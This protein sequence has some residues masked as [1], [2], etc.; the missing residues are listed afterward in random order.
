MKYIQ[1]TLPCSFP[2]ADSKY[3]INDAISRGKYTF[4]RNCS[5][6]D[7]N[8]WLFNYLS[9]FLFDFNLNNESILNM[10]NNGSK[11]SNNKT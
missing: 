2:L 9:H 1:F 10:V 6:F 3:I 5:V 11:H 7:E 4:G 8:A